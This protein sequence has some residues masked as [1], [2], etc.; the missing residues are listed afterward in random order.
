MLDDDSLDFGNQLYSISFIMF[1]N[2]TTVKWSEHF[3]TVICFVSR[4]V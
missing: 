3:A 1:D 4:N 2:N